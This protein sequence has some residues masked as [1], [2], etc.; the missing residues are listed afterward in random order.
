MAENLLFFSI[1][2]LQIDA[3]EIFK[4]IKYGKKYRR[5]Y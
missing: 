1:D 5:K 4:N 3:T 2:N